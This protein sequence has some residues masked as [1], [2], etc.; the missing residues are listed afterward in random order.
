MPKDRSLNLGQGTDIEPNR[1]DPDAP[2]GQPPESLTT[3]VDIRE[4]FDKP[5]DHLAMGK[6]LLKLPKIDSLDHLLVEEDGVWD[7]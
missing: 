5:Q 1:W 6:L 4:L 2:G 7:V 3:P